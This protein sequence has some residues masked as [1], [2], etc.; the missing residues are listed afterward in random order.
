MKFYSIILRCSFLSWWQIA[1]FLPGLK[2]CKIIFHYPPFTCDY[3]LLPTPIICNLVPRV[4]ILA[5]LSG[6]RGSRPWERGCIIYCNSRRLRQWFPVNNYS[7]ISLPKVDI[8]N[9]LSVLQR[10]TIGCQYFRCVMRCSTSYS[11]PRALDQYGTLRWEGR[12]SW[13][14]I[15]PDNR[16]ATSC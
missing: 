11:P 15:W 3:P 6:E 5:L 16:S 9:S 2:S 4:L 13:D 8:F 14:V 1:P 10:S 12:L 7:N